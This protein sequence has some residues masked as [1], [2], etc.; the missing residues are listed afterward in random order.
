MNHVSLTTSSTKPIRHIEPDLSLTTLPADVMPNIFN[1]LS[2]AT[3][4]FGLAC[5]SKEVH[6]LVQPWLRDQ[7]IHIL[8]TFNPEFL[9]RSINRLTP[10]FRTGCLHIFDQAWLDML[11][12]ARDKAIDRE[13]IETLL[14]SFAADDTKLPKLPTMPKPQE[15]AAVAYPHPYPLEEDH[16]AWNRTFATKVIVEAGISE[17][18]EADRYVTDPT[19]KTRQVS[20]RPGWERLVEI[21]MQIDICDQIKLLLRVQVRE[22]DNANILLAFEE[23]VAAHLTTLIATD[24]FI[25]PPDDFRAEEI[26]RYYNV[27]ADVY[28]LAPSQGENSFFHSLSKKNSFSWFPDFLHWKENWRGPC[29][30]MF[31]LLAYEARKDQ[32]ADIEAWSNPAKDKVLKK[33]ITHKELNHFVKKTNSRMDR[34]M[35]LELAV[36]KWIDENQDPGKCVIC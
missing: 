4:F 14:V 17:M 27:L 36:S 9:E 2:P 30:L 34:G 15:I 18:M 29:N 6:C 12:R 33:F 23:L 31:R 13:L 1:R 35:R 7:A 10:L 25:F 5:T 32:T 22:F 28:T 20:K 3:D 19:L 11:T 21:F 24:C 26:D 16:S 8:D